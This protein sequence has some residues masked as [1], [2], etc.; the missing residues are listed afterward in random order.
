MIDATPT[1]A[2]ASPTLTEQLQQSLQ[3]EQPPA[4]AEKQAPLPAT[5]PYPTR[6]EIAQSL[7]GFKNEAEAVKV[8]GE[9]GWKEAVD[10]HYSVMQRQRIYA[11]G[12][13]PKTDQAALRGLG[14][15]QGVI[16]KMKP[17]VARDILDK[18]TPAAVETR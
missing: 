5:A 3:Q 15:D 4:P 6:N 18:Q 9:A 11:S 16:N 12:K 17:D 13:I 8:L 2:A 7:Y 14:Y 10:R 1:P